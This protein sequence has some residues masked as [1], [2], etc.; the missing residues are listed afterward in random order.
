VTGLAN[1]TLAWNGTLGHAA[2]GSIEAN[3]GFSSTGAAEA[4]FIRYVPSPHA[5]ITGRTITAWVYV[6]STS[7][8]IQLQAYAQSAI[9]AQAFQGGASFTAD[10][11]DTPTWTMLSFVIPPANTSWDPTM[12][13][14]FGI[15]VTTLSTIPDAGATSVVAVDDYV[16]Q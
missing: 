15:W 8:S 14:Q 5:D 7:V 6:E 10:A 13:N 16:V 2:P 11:G 1:P 4:A 9:S 12:M 3:I